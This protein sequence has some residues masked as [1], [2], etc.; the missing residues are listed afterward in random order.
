MSFWKES[1]IN[2][3]QFLSIVG[4]FRS[5]T[6]RQNK[7]RTIHHNLTGDNIDIDACIASGSFGAIFRAENKDT[8]RNGEPGTKYAIKVMKVRIDTQA[9]GEWEPTGK[10]GEDY[11]P[12]LSRTS[13]ASIEDVEEMMRKS[14]TAK[15]S[16]EFRTSLQY[17]KTG[18]PNVCNME[19]WAEFDILAHNYSMLIMELCDYGDIHDIVNNFRKKK[20]F[21]PEGFM[22]SFM[23]CS[24][25][26]IAYIMFLN[27]S[28][29][30]IHSNK[31]LTVL[32][33]STASIQITENY[34]NSRKI[35]P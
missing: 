5:R 7:W 25:L 28:P 32:H 8:R 1:A 3:N 27:L 22:V 11:S 31:Y 4:A 19:G 33:F 29:S 35:Y 2:A 13:E 34:M 15:R 16:R 6:I 12:V 24:I 30:G 26:R 10:M 20:E 14:L 17:I 21:I 18:H 23:Q 9:E